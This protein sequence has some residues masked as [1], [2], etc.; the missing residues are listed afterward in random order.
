[1]GQVYSRLYLNPWAA[2]P[3]AGVLTKLSTVSWNNG[4]LEPTPG[5]W[6]HQLLGIEP[7]DI[8]VLE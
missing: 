5:A 7:I 4:S 3:Y 1:L 6:L 2:R 8:S